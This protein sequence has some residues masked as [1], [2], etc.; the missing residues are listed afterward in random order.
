MK[1]SRKCSSAHV[2]S[3]C[4]NPVEIVLRIVSKNVAQSPETVLK[5]HSFSEFDF[6][7]RWSSGNMDCNS[8]NRVQMFLAD[9]KFSLVSLLSNK[10]SF[11]KFPCTGGN[12][13]QKRYCR[14]LQQ[15]SVIHSFKDHKQNW[16][17][18]F[19]SE[20]YFLLEKFLWTRRMHLRQL[21][22]N[23]TASNL[24]FFAQF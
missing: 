19:A 17:D 1:K 20:I 16:K 15:T 5:L 21:C 7:H 9:D 3:K 6:F 8:D 14:M 2:Q 18:I 24:V 12:H 13:W 22:W 4:G 11:K 10:L 23:F